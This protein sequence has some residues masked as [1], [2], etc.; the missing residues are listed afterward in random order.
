MKTKLAI[1]TPPK[2]N[3]YAA[4]YANYIGAVG[5]ANVLDV[6]TK[7]RKSTKSILSKL[8]EQKGNHRYADDK[9]SI[10]ELIGHLIDTERIMTFRALQFYR[11]DKNELA[12]FDQDAYVEAA[13]FSDRSLA[14]VTK[15][16]DTVRAATLALFTSFK[17]ENLGRAGMA[18]GYLMTVKA[19]M[20]VVAGHEIHHIGIL[21]DRY[22]K[23]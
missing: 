17:K 13:D 1:I 20:Y 10:K 9:W 4:F 6:L 11:K 5:D 14:E 3:E 23:G 7:S 12:G 16:F 21:N 22:L 15:E 8:S 19:L 18:S 2:P